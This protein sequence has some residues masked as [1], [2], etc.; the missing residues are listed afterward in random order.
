MRQPRSKYDG[1]DI[2][3][4]PSHDTVQGGSRLDKAANTSQSACFA[5]T[6]T[7]QQHVAGTG[8]R[9]LYPLNQ[10]IPS[11]ASILVGLLEVFFWKRLG[12]KTVWQDGHTHKK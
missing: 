7:N 2:L 3:V 8:L 9:P 1:P 12:V 6:D 11:S 5:N 10:Y 4:L